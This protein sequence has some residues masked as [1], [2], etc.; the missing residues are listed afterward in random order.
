MLPFGPELMLERVVRLVGQA[1]DPVVVVAAAGQDLPELP[2]EIV[3]VCDRRPDQ[4]PLEGLAVGLKALEDRAEAAFVTA[5][6]VPLL[7]P[8]FVRRVIE[9][10]PGFDIAVPHVDGF[11]EPLAA[12]YR[13]SVLDEVE[14]LLELNRRRPAFLFEKT[15]TRR[16]TA[17]ELAD[18]DS[19]L[20]S[21]ANVNSPDDYCAALAK[22]GFNL[23]TDG[24]N[25]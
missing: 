22:A 10:L 5:C 13:T 6:D 20:D 9:M 16:I 14:S 24:D 23:P 12:V 1:V 3:V 18:I 21:L 2:S 19:G 4:G 25:C 7:V 15:V 17:A 11:D 8:A